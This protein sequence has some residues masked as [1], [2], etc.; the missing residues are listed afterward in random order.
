[1]MRPKK[2]KEERVK[3][4]KE[5]LQTAKGIF[6]YLRPYSGSYIIGWI[7]LVLSTGAGFAFPYLMG[8]LLGGTSTEPMSMTSSISAINLSNINSVAF[9]L[10]ILFIGQAVFSYFRV[11]LFTNVTENALRDVRN[12][13]FQKL[14]YMPMDFFNA[15]KVG[16]LTSRISNDITQIQETLRTTVAEFFRQLVVVIGG[17]VL[18][19][20]FSWKLA[21]IML[22]TVP[23]MAIIAVIFGKYIKRLSKQAQDYSAESNSILEEALMGIANVKSFTN[24]LFVFGKFKKSTQE[25]RNLNVKSGLWRGAF[26][27]FIIFCLFGAIVFIIWQGLLMT[28]GPNPELATGDFFS[29]VMYTVMMGASVGSLPELYAGIQKSVGATE[30]LML[31]INKQSEREMNTGKQKPEITGKVTFDN[32]GFAYPQRPDVTVLKHVS[33]KANSNETIAFVGQSGAGKSTMASL[34][35]N[36]YPLLKGSITFDG[37]NANDIDLEYL[38][39]HI[40]IV[41]QEVILFAGTIRENILF[42]NPDATEEQ[43]IEAAKQA[44]A[45]D[46]IT[47]FPEQFETQV[48]DRGIQLSGGQKQRIAIARAILKNPTILILDEATSALDNESEKLVQDAL[49]KLM[50]GRTSFVIAHRLTTIRKADKIF[51]LNNG[52]IVETG[53]HNELLEQKGVYSGLVEIQK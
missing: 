51:V 48:G 20:Y 16:E 27:S 4:T 3:I 43:V 12:D 46:F 26:I 42:G 29:F 37:V 5:S 35:L 49:D 15:N 50:K 45:F 41:P 7:F 18:L 14:I 6:A 40:A 21:L 38:R 44:N 11:V 28:Q 36:Y 52:E 33:F 23:V 47:S 10:L 32:V 53:T 19:F 9:V 22:A 13:A 17:V 39:S 30:N 31:I 34:I 1:M 2:K 24:E 25:I 8:Q